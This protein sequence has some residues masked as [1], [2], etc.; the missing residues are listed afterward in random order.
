[1]QDIIGRDLGLLALIST[2]VVHTKYLSDDTELDFRQKIR[3]EVDGIIARSK[4]MSNEHEDD[5][6]K[7]AARNIVNQVFAALER[8]QRSRPRP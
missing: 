6:A 1:M 3:N 2:L 4:L 8:F 7:E 5:E